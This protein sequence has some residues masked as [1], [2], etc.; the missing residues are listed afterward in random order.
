[1]VDA[2]SGGRRGNYLIKGP[3]LGGNTEVCVR[4]PQLAT[5]DNKQVCFSFFFGLECY[6]A[7]ANAQRVRVL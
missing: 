2:N 4:G 6:A 3:L 1:M 7:T 5:A